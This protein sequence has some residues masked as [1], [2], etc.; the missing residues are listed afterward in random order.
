MVNCDAALGDTV[1]MPEVAWVR[2]GDAVV[3]RTVIASATS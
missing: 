2:T 1:T 3:K